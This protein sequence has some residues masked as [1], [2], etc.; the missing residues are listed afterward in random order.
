MAR[1]LA[2]A[3]KSAGIHDRGEYAHQVFRQQPGVTGAE[4]VFQAI[5]PFFISERYKSF[6][7]ACDGLSYQMGET[8]G[9]R[10]HRVALWLRTPN[11]GVREPKRQ[12]H[13]LADNEHSNGWPP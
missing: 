11:A 10:S 12:R 6:P 5:W 2:K 1:V 9:R 3:R 8:S 13:G 4:T 7:D